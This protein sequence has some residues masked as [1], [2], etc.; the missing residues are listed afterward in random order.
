ML[1]LEYSGYIAG[2]PAGSARISVEHS[3]GAY[4]V[5]GAIAT[6]GLMHRI[7]PWRARFIAAGRLRDGVA[8]PQAL[9]VTESARRKTRTIHVASGVLRQRRNGKLRPQRP[10]PAGTDLMSALWAAPR[11]AAEH[12]L[13]NGRHAYVMTLRERVAK[14]DGTE[15]CFY[16]IVDDEGDR[17]RGWIA[18]GER[19]G[20]RVPLQIV[21]VEGVTR[22]LQLANAKERR[23][24]APGFD[25]GLREAV[26]TVTPALP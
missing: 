12:T 13:H 25:W 26:R 6:H 4:T 8:M 22:R 5:R 9:A 11:C 16:D 14:A 20:V 19:G 3:D 1:E 23:A 10:A 18:L 24:G 17:S 7:S 15:R 2:A 21:I